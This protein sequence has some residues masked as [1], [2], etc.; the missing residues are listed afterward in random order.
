MRQQCDLAGPVGGEAREEILEIRVRVVPIEL[1][2]AA[3][4]SLSRQR[5]APPAANLRPL[6]RPIVRGRIWFST[7]VLFVRASCRARRR[8]GRI[9]RVPG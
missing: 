6:T 7:V 5:A 9:V 2:A 1:R 4:D 8:E 3:P